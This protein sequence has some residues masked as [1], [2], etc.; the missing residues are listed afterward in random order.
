MDISEKVP[1]S[2]KEVNHILKGKGILEKDK[3]EVNI[4]IS[5][6]MH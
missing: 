6:V 5:S 4:Y 3:Y 2:E 1:M